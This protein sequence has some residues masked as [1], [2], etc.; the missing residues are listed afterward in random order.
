MSQ[1]PKPPNRLDDPDFRNAEIA[2]HRAAKKAQQR[3]RDAGLE[4]VVRDVKT[5][6]QP[7]EVDQKR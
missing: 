4:P 3:A 7:T 1:P 6:A 5:T 2:L